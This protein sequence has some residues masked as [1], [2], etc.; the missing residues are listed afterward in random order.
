MMVMTEMNI[1]DD[2]ENVMLVLMKLDG[3]LDLNKN[4]ESSRSELL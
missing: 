1:C 3:S 4:H 2:K